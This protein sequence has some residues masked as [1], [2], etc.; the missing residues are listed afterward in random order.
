MH[1]HT[2]YFSKFPLF[3]IHSTITFLRFH[4]LHQSK[5][6]FYIDFAIVISV[7]LN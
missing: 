2:Q 5:K 6:V 4:F 1:N 7:F 3:M